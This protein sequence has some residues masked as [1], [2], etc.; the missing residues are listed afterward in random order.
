VPLL[1]RL[2]DDRRAGEV[3]PEPV[4]LVDVFAT[5]LAT[6]GAPLPPKPRAGRNLLA[7][8]DAAAPVIAEYYFPNQ[9]LAL[10]ERDSQQGPPPQL[11]PYLRRLRSIELGGLRFVWGSDGRNELYDLAADPDER[12]DVSADPR[13]ADRAKALRAE[14]D[15]FVQASGG[16]TPLPVAAPTTEGVFEDLDPES[17][18]LLR[19]LGYLP[20]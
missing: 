1:I 9:A 13:F 17:A 18:R 16:P 20:D 3:R 12:T 15:A 14:L 8:L 4:A 7:P 10:F 6:A 5:L 2:P 11:A 19:E